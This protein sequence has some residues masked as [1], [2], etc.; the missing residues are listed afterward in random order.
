MQVLLDLGDAYFMRQHL[1]QAEQAYSRALAQEPGNTAA[2][3]GLAMVWHAQGDSQRAEKTLAALVKAH[4]DDQD[5]HYSLA[6]VYFSDG[7]TGPGPAGVADGGA[8]RPHLGDGP[9]LAE[10]RRPHRR[11]RVGL[12][13]SRQLSEL[14]HARAQHVADVRERE[15]VELRRVVAGGVVGLHE[16]LVHQHLVAAHLEVVHRVQHADVGAHAGDL[17]HLGAEPP[18][19]R[20]ELRAAE[21]G[22]G[23]LAHHGP[24]VRELLELGHDLVLAR[25]LHA[26][27]WGTS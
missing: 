27:D 2:Q 17:D 21:P 6:I 7:R 20:V 13:R 22:E 1:Q 14:L 26:V 15:A 11:Q 8:H 18:E 4:P 10:L 25:A 5:A 19:D 16:V 9:A 3:V 23:V 24:T 12:S